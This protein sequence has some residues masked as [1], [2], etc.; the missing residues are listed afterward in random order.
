[1]SRFPEYGMT[2]SVFNT[3]TNQI[4]P[5]EPCDPKRLKIYACGV[6]VYDVCHI[7]H[8]MQAIIY[9]VIRNYFQ[10]KGM[11]VTYVRNY[12]DVDDK[13]IHR[14]K[15]LGIP[16]LVHS[17]LMIQESQADLALLGVKPA[18]LEPKVSENIPEIVEMIQTI[19]DKHGAYESNGDVYFSVNGFEKYGN[20]S[21]RCAEDMRAGS[22][23]EINPNK[24]DPLDFALWKKA[25]PGE[26]SWPSPWGE[27]RPGW[28]IE[29]SALALKFLGR[30]FDIH[31]GGKDLIFPHHE[32]EIAQ[33]ETATGC[34]MARYWIHNGLVTVDGRKMSKTLKNYMSIRDAVAKYHPETIRY[35]ILAHHYSSNIDFSEKT[36]YDS[37]QRLIYFYNTLKRVAQLLVDYPEVPQELPQNVN[38]PDIE[39][40]FQT[41][42]DD[43]FNTAIALREIGLAFK[44]INDFI[45]AKKP[46]LKQ[47][48]FALDRTVTSLKNCLSV[49]G[50]LQTEP[51]TAL[52][53]IQEYLIKDHAIDIQ[54]VEKLIADRTTARKEKDWKKADEIRE[55]LA[56]ECIAVMDTPAGTEWQVTP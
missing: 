5:F 23:V 46:K 14:A 44:W 50:L 1:M 15:E 8:A 11:E 39:N 34:Q 52:R 24:R 31:G 27:G 51:E 25:K 29:C 56:A 10:Y 3:L 54:R 42:M 21:N 9:D 33:T 48:V 49:L 38:I 6:T 13:I 40:Q 37:Y 17:E 12:T 55:I 47:K 28:H 41:A 20:L 32:N 4:E 53:E 22:R 43:D 45:A 26:I 36:F 16:P 30:Q 18:D 19:I 2:L 35:T 7:G